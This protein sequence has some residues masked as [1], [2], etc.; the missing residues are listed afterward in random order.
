MSSDIYIRYDRRAELDGT[1]TVFDVITG[2]PA[3]IGCKQLTELAE[4]NA[5]ELTD[6]LNRIPVRD[7][8]RLPR[9]A[10]QGLPPHTHGVDLGP[11]SPGSAPQP[12]P[13]L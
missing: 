5:A 7:R 10:T 12:K 4:K 13:G 2:Y 9:Q 1:W 11:N 8:W 3:M 6:M